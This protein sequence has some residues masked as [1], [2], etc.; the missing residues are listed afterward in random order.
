MYMNKGMP[1]E[2]QPVTALHSQGGR[3]YVKPMDVLT[4]EPAQRTLARFKQSSIYKAIKARES[5]SSSAA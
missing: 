2:K 4:S 1:S 5:N 3:L